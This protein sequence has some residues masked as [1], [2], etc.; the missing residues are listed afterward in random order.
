MY[1]A[2][3]VP[4]LL[5]STCGSRLLQKRSAQLRPDT[6]ALL[7]KLKHD[8]AGVFHGVATRTSDSLLPVKESCGFVD[9]ATNN[10]RVRRDSFPMRHRSVAVQRELR[11]KARDT[12]VQPQPFPR[13]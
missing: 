4:S 12:L 7:Q 9:K 3:V 8:L 6:P 11:G 1:A 5:A 10:V 13:R 2:H